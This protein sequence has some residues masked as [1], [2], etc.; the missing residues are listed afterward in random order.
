MNTTFDNPIIMQTPNWSYGKKRDFGP[1]FKSAKSDKIIV[2]FNKGVFFL[3]GVDFNY[4]IEKDSES[5]DSEDDSSEENE[6]IY[7]KTAINPSIVVTEPCGACLSYS[8]FPLFI[9]ASADG[10]IVFTTEEMES[11]RKFSKTTINKIDS[12]DSSLS[13][14]SYSVDDADEELYTATDE[15]PLSKTAIALLIPVMCIEASKNDDG[16]ILIDSVMDMRPYDSYKFTENED[17]EEPDTDDDDKDKDPGDDDPNPDLSQQGDPCEDADK[18]G[19]NNGAKDKGDGSKDGADDDPGGGGGGGDG[20]EVGAIDCGG[21]DGTGENS[22]KEEE[23]VT[24]NSGEG[25]DTS[26]SSSETTQ[27]EAKQRT[28]NENSGGTRGSAIASLIGS[29]YVKE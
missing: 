5:G 2:K 3:R 26:E 17:M 8:D 14:R 24:G 9:F 22:S 13:A 10:D 7:F 27:N 20:G 23:V 21:E 18:K 28:I 1:L 25:T 12:S 4:K 11:F 6:K 29:I 19:G 16:S 15:V